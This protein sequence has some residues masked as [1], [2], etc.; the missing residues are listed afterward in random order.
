MSAK[1]PPLPKRMHKSYRQ[2]G[3][4][5]HE[6]FLKTTG[7]VLLVLLAAFFVDFGQHMVKP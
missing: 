7:L 3:A 6:A 1:P 5:S 2:R 4:V